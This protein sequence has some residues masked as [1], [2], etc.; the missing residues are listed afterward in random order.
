MSG[1][2]THDAN[3]IRFRE[4]F[5]ELVE[6]RMLYQLQ[7]TPGA[8][9][10]PEIR[11]LLV[12]RFKQEKQDGR[13]WADGASLI[14]N[15]HNQ[16]YAPLLWEAWET[17]P[18]F[19]APSTMGKADIQRE[20]FHPKSILLRAVFELGDSDTMGKV[21]QTFPSVDEGDQLLVANAAGTMLDPVAA[22]DV[23]RGVEAAKSERVRA[24]LVASV[25]R[26]IYHVV[27]CNSETDRQ[28]ALQTAG[29]L[30]AEM[31][32]RGMLAD[33]LGKILSK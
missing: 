31:R 11:R 15:T 24:A 4:R 10:D 7:L 22:T 17:L 8:L 16:S 27:T 20:L 9:E 25:N 18:V 21:W 26:M 1:R 14:G 29:P 32:S 5:S 19:E 33:Y 3:I 13:F 23:L 2:A 6:T 28:W 30:I 12:E